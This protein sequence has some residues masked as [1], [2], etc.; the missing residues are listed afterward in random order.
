[1]D[2]DTKKQR[3]RRIFEMV[4]SNRSFDGIMANECPDFLV[5]QFPTS[6]CFGVEITEVYNSETDARLDRISGYVD[7]L[8]DGGGFKHKYDRKTLNITEVDIVRE[9][10]SIVAS[11]IPAICQEVPPPSA[12]AQQIAKRIRS[13]AERLQNAAAKMSHVNLIIQDNTGLLR[14]IRTANFYNNFFVPEL[15]SALAETPFREVFLVTALEDKQVYVGL[16]ML[17]LLAEAYLFNGV[18]VSQGFAKELPPHV[19]DI[20]LFASYLASIVKSP[21]LIHRDTVGIEVIFGDSGIMFAR[22]D[23][24]TVRLHS[25]CPIHPDAARPHLQWKAILGIDFHDAMNEYRKTHTFC[26]AVAFP[27][28]Q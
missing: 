26:T 6:L 13:K 19:D 7:Q 18:I 14:S 8:L 28:V 10:N 23:T 11:N 2:V 16:K 4:Y 20:E 5:R 1:M 25:D 15:I 24:V 9:D 22:H 12:C 3:E 21:V 27:I 17:Y